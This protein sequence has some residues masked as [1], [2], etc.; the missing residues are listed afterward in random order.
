MLLVVDPDQREVRRFIAD[1]EVV[2]SLFG[3]AS[4]NADSEKERSEDKMRCFHFDKSN[5]VLAWLPE[6]SHGYRGGELD[7]A[8]LSPSDFILFL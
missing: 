2:D 3:V 6:I 4:R 5:K 1:F 8:S 7:S